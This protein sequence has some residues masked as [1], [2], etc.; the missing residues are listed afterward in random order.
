LHWAAGSGHFETVEVLIKAGADVN[1]VNTQGDTP[2]H[3]A[4]WKGGE[5]V[6]ALLVEHGAG[7]SREV[8][9]KDGKKPVDLARTLEVRKVVAP[10]LPIGTSIFFLHFS[11]I[12]GEDEEFDQEDEDSD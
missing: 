6:C 9:N 11:T 5:K 3:R 8:E 2:L 1:A 12:I 4:A 7:P 10:P